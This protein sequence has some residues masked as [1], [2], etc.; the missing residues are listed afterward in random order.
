MSSRAEP[1]GDTPDLIGPR[2]VV[3][4]DGSASSITA[5]AWAAAEAQ[6]RGAALEVVH[7]NF[8]R[9]EA[10]QA[11]APGMLDAETSVLEHA[12]G[13]AKTLAPNI[14][15]TGRVCEPPAGEALIAASEGAEMLVVGS[16]GLSGL[17]AMTLGSVSS[18]CAHRALCPVV[19]IRLPIRQPAPHPGE[20]LAGSSSARDSR[21]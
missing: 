3:G 6:L 12:V 19:I 20:D 5:L 8:A 4:V 10:L 7:S 11:L 18:E 15:V 21:P 1:G 14:P 13:R 9:R 2:I 17:K 16:R